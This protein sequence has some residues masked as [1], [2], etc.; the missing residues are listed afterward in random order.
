MSNSYPLHPLFVS[1]VP[2]VEDPG[3][4]A[5][6]LAKEFQPFWRRKSE[7]WRRQ[8]IRITPEE[9]VDRLIEQR[10]LCGICHRHYSIGRRMLAADHSHIRDDPAIRGLLD[11]YCNYEF[12]RVELA[13]SCGARIRWTPE[14]ARYLSEFRKRAGEL[15][16]LPPV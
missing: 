6:V 14:Q 12:G 16:V 2:V 4:K 13:I 1:M 3:F 9:Y 5:F 8:G 10:G 15:V 11:H 7:S